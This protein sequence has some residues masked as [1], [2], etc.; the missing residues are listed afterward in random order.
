MI[1]RPPRSTRT[2]TL[3]PYT[4]LFRSVGAAADTVHGERER[5]VR[6]PADRAEAHRAGG[7]TLHDLARGL[8]LL[9]RDGVFRKLEV[10]QYAKG[11]QT[12]VLL[13]DLGCEGGIFRRDIAAHG[14]LK[15]RDR[16][17]RPEIGRAAGRERVWQYV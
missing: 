9:D 16:L 3:F 11:Q 8:H 7:E 13:V 6:F 10:H 2:D 1:R 15:P 5:G 17:R 14:V 4:T 12:L